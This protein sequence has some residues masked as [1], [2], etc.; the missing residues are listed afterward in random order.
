M[1][2]RARLTTLLLAGALVAGACQLGASIGT[3]NT[4]ILALYHAWGLHYGTAA[5]LSNDLHDAEDAEGKSDIAQQKGTV[6]LLFHQA[7]PPEAA[8][9]PNPQASGALHFTWVILEIERQHCA[10][11][12]DELA[13]RGQDSQHLRTLLGTV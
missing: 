8:E 13:E 3:D 7:T 11:I 6:P 5:Q 10:A 1:P 2:P 4:E 12:A 9:Q